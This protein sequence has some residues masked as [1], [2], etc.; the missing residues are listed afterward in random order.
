M[1]LTVRLLGVSRDAENS[2]SLIVSFDGEPTDD[3]LRAV[4]DA[5]RDISESFHERLGRE[6]REGTARFINADGSCTADKLR[7]H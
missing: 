4:S 1:K 6:M 3:D 5:V 2:K 7:R